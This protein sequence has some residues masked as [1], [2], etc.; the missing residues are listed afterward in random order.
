MFSA[1][2]CAPA[3]LAAAPR[4]FGTSCG[5]R[6]RCAAI[7]ATVTEE[8]PATAS[9]GGDEEPQKTLTPQA[10]LAA[11]PG[12]IPPTGLFDP[13]NL[14]QGKTINNLNRYR[15]AELTH[16]RV[17][18]LAFIGAVVG[19]NFNPL[20]GGSITGP[21]INQF[22]QVPRPFWELVV[23]GIGLAEASRVSRGW[24]NPTAIDGSSEA[25]ELFELRDDYTPG[26]LDFDPLGLKP[27]SQSELLDI[28]NKEL[29]NG[30]VAML[31][32]ATLVLE[33]LATE[34]P[35]L[36]FTT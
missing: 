35:I 21:F 34:E 23:F 2:L 3:R 9:T 17:C 25:R 33:E 36:K 20:F 13:A 26:D 24:A 12:I 4:R 14:T 6:R 18:M 1:S 8:T 27:K 22:Q 7:R 5:N 11:M 15:E 10:H 32:V 16:G 19:E 29:S 31:A 28:K 30:R